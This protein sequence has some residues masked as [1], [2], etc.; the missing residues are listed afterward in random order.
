M[1]SDQRLCRTRGGAVVAI[2]GKVGRDRRDLNGTGV[3]VTSVNG[4]NSTLEGAEEGLQQSGSGRR[5]G[6]AGDAT[7]A[8]TTSADG[9]DEPQEDTGSALSS[10]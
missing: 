5:E 4:T 10:E 6:D 2:A 1:C 8:N 3:N 7:G 9:G